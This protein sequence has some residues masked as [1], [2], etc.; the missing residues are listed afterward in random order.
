MN[1]F[2]QNSDVWS[3]ATLILG[4]QRYSQAEAMALLYRPVR[5]DVSLLLAGQLIAAKLN[6]LNLAC[7]LRVDAPLAGAD[8]L[9]ARFA[10]KLPYHVSAQDSAG[11]AMLRHAAVLG[12]YNAGLLPSKE[13]FENA[14]Q[15]NQ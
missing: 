13:C 4:N 5:G 12:A 2:R 14:R 8:G 7:S 9:L 1:Y 3:N 6:V 10:G 15:P 11:A